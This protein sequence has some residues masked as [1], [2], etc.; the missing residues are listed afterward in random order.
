MIDKTKKFWRGF[1]ADDI[2]E[3][4]RLYSGCDD[5]DIKPV[6]CHSFGNDAFE[7]NL[8]NVESTVQIKCTRCGEEKIILD[9][10]D[11]WEE[12]SPE[13][14]KCPVCKDSGSF[15][16]K[17]GF[18]R[19]EDGD[20]KWVYIGNRCTNCGTLGSFTDWEINFAPTDEM[21]KNI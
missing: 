3:Y 19:R 21:E 18:I 9:C 5:I 16:M 10:E 17:V 4:L 13:F 15:N 12:S 20:V 2:D 11:I 1:S 6:I 8:D 14:Q 7:V